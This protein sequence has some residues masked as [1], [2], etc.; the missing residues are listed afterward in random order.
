[1]AAQGYSGYS[2][3]FAVVEE[4]VASLQVEGADR[5][6]IQNRELQTASADFRCSTEIQRVTA[7]VEAELAQE[8][9]AEASLL[10][11]AEAD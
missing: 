2:D 3:S 1:M 7:T 5:A 11:V 6:A 4:L 10:L 8:F 9:Y